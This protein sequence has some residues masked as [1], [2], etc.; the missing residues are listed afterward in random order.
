[1]KKFITLIITLTML[2][3][4]VPAEAAKGPSLDFLKVSYKNYMYSNISQDGTLE[5]KLNE[6]I[7]V[8]N[9]V[10]KL[11]DSNDS[12]VD[13]KAM[14]E[15]LFDSK[16][17]YTAKQKTSNSGE[18]S[19]VEMHMKTNSPIRLNNNLE[20]AVNTN[21]SI[22]ADLDISDAEKP[23]MNYIMSMPTNKRY[24]TM[25]LNDFY[26]YMDENQLS[27]YNDAMGMIS[28]IYSSDEFLLQMQDKLVESISDN[29]KVTGTVGYVKIEFSDLGLKKYVADAFEV[30][31]DLYDEEMKEELMEQS[32]E[33]VETL[34]DVA[35]NVPFFAENALVL[36]YKL[37]SKDRIISE[38]A[39]LNV[40]LDLYK[41]ITYLGQDTD[42]L[43][44]GNSNISF[45][46]LSNTTFKYN[47]VTINK[48]EITK[49]NS[50]SI[51]ELMP[52]Y[53]TPDYQEYEPE[54][55]FF[56]YLYVDTDENFY[57]SNGEKYIPLRALLEAFNYEVTYDNGV[58]KATSDSKYAEYDNIEFNIKENVVN[59]NTVNYTISAAPIIVND[60]SYITLTDAEKVMNFRTFLYSYYP[61]ENTGYIDVE[62][63]AQEEDFEAVGL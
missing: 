9:F 34:K 36:E 1:M 33:F 25:N 5:F 17:T 51:M 45:S 44:D 28:E 63:N 11:F 38:K 60:K 3:S 53:E 54:E 6:P 14:V 22:W 27:E 18:K 41:L 43:V 15:S 26:S 31:M 12:P 2:I 16:I 29:A 47:T 59:T 10:D 50:V 19:S 55:Y 62:R 39:E 21:Y 58:I 30:A 57:G 35:K 61:S 52:V 4:I 7:S 40:D 23:L 56:P 20:L 48:P 8:L 24:V 37:D 32:E 13:I 42:D 49:D 46:M